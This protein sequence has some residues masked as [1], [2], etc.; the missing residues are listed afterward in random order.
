MPLTLTM[1]MLA[2]T[3]QHRTAT[4]TAGVGAVRIIQLPPGFRALLR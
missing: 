2:A 1:A 3:L 4:K